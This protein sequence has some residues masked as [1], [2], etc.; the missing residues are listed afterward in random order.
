MDDTILLMGLRNSDTEV[1]AEVISCYSAYVSAIIRNQLSDG[2]SEAD[3]EELASEVFFLLWQK[4]F[5]IKT[6]HLRG[7]LGTV[8]KNQAR[9]FRRKRKLHTVCIE[10]V[11]LIKDDKAEELL[12]QRERSRIL[13]LAL[14]ELG[15]PDSQVLKLYYFH[16]LTV[17]AIA[18]HLHL[19]PE[20]VKSKIR[21]GRAKLKQILRAGGYLA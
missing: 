14:Q 6:T 16:E 10:D 1:L 7:W 3:I 5:S 13:N 17:P 11:L 18:E 21:R 20:A 19:H 2:F 8:A 9:S 12:E 4:R 15:E